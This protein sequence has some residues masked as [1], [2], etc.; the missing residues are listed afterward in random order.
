ME[1]L[2]GI[3]LNVGPVHPAAHGVLKVVVDIEGDTVNKAQVEMGFLH[4]GKEKMEE[5]R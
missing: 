1:T 5:V 3:R 4:R 2:K